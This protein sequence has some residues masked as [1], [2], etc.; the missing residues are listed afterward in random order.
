[1]KIISKIQIKHFRSFFE[2]DDLKSLGEFNIFAGANDSGKSN[3]LKALNLFF[4]NQTS[5]LDRFNFEDDYSKLSFLKA[6]EKKKGRQFITI[7]IYFNKDE[8]N[9]KAGLK[10]FVKKQLEELW[11]E[12][13]WWKYEEQY[14]EKVPDY[15]QNSTQ[16]IKASFSA[17]LNEIKFIY[18]PAFKNEDVFA[19]VLKL[20]GDNEG[21]F[22]DANAKNTLNEKIAETTAEISRDFSNL[23]G[24]DTMLSLPITLESFWSALTVASVFKEAAKKALSRGKLE[25]YYINFSLRGEGIKS[26]FVP[27]ILGWLAKSI[28]T[29]YWIWGV[30]EPENSLESSR[31]LNVF[32]KFVDYSSMA[33]IFVSS[34]SPIFIFPRQESIKKSDIRVYLARQRNEGDTQLRLINDGNGKLVNEGKIFNELTKEFGVDYISFL[35]LQQEYADKIQEKEIQIG[36]LKSEIKEMSKPIIFLEGEI[37]E[38]YFKKTLEL[39]YANNYPAEIKRV[40]QKDKN[41]QEKFTGKDSLSKIKQLYEA[42]S[43]S[44][45]KKVILFYDVECKEQIKSEGNLVIYCPIED[46]AAQYK[47]GIEHL[48]TIPANFDKLHY[49]DT[50]QRGDKTITMP[51]KK[52]ICDYIMSLNNVDE[53]K[54]WLKKISSILEEIKNTYLL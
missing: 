22:L 8:I 9:G 51:N 26:I 45:Q 41:G 1:M 18:I 38:K 29:K 52:K 15:I 13:T 37:D 21:V 49:Q 3:A 46:A 33:Q 19:H 11:V 25:D 6:R 54:Q 50:E 10:K 14:R 42:H 48:L 2:C 39:F 20:A 28:R 53:Q 17:F 4:N 47:T 40:G 16:G 27:V 35:E 34:H 31:A 36:K 23:T 32:S 30:D 5:F 12:R 24:I 7:R 44:F 43:D